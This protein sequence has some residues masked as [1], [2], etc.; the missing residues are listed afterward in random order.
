MPKAPVPANA[1]NIS[2]YSSISDNIENTA[3]RNLSVVG[4]VFELSGE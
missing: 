4:R 2:G 1:S 3:E